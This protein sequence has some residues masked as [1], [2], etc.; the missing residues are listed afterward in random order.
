MVDWAWFINW[1]YCKV[2]LSFIVTYTCWHMAGKIS[3][4]FYTRGLLKSRD[5][6]MLKTN[7]SLRGKKAQ[8]NFYSWCLWLLWWGKYSYVTFVR[9]H[10]L[11]FFHLHILHEKQDFHLLLPAQCG[12]ILRVGF[13]T[14]I[15]AVISGSLHFF[16][17]FEWYWSCHATINSEPTCNGFIPNQ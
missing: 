16:S 3:H 11:V 10:L 12:V 2:I 17:T 14:L 1:S 4:M 8:S 5:S 15:F 9:S 7:T 13:L 6:H